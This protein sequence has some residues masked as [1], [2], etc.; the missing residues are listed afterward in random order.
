[1]AGENDKREFYQDK[2]GE[3]RWRRIARNGQNV[4]ASCEGYTK[5]SDATAN[6]ERHGYKKNPKGLGKSDTWEIYKDKKGEYRWRRTAKNGERVG[7]AT[8]GYSAR[9]SCVANAKRNGMK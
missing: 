9:S 4:G 1:M 7:A 8:E 6:A 5:A 2:K 3:N